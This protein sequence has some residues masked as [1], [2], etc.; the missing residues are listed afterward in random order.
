MAVFNSCLIGLQPLMHVMHIYHEWTMLAHPPKHSGS[1]PHMPKHPFMLTASLDFFFFFGQAHFFFAL[2]L[3]NLKNSAQH[4][5]IHSFE[6]FYCGGIFGVYWLKCVLVLYHAL[7]V[8]VRSCPLSTPYL[9]IA[10]I[11][12]KSG[13]YFTTSK[14]DFTVVWG[15]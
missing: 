4:T 13:R 10:I 1:S 14:F 6:S 11:V 15:K 3:Y 7:V 8:Y 9:C 5:E 12:T 2:S